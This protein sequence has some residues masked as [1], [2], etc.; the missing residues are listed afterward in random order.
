MIALDTDVLVRYVVEDDAQQSEAARTLLE[1]LTAEQPGYVCR[2]VFVEFSWMLGRAYRFSRDQIATIT[3]DLVA[4]E[5]LRFET[6]EDAIRVA[7][8]SRHGEASF[9]DRMFAAAAK[10]SGSDALFTF[11]Q[12]ASRIPGAVPLVDPA[13][14]GRQKNSYRATRI[15]EWGGSHNSGI[16][17]QTPKP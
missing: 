13:R 12:Q 15:I 7:D 11:D 2:E 8:G 1:R 9:A 14:R 10:C 16:S 5:E 6:A 4:S 3:V 17:L